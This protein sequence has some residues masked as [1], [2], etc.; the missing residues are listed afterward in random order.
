MIKRITNFFVDIIQKYLP[1]AFVFAI[2]LTII[3]L[4][5]GIIFTGQ[6]LFE[7]ITHWGDGVWGLLAFSMQMALVLVLGHTLAESNFVKRIIKA[8]TKLAN[9]PEQAIFFVSLISAIAC[10]LNWGFGLVIGALYARE[11]VKRI[12]DVDYRLLI[13]SAYSGFIVWHGGF[14]ASIPLTLA[15][16]EADLARETAGAITQAIPTSLTIFS[17]F[18]LILS[19][20]IIFTLPFLN[21]LMLPEEKDRVKVNPALLEEEEEIII[22]KNT[23]AEKIEN[24]KIV[25]YITGGIG[26]VYLYIYFS[27]RGFDLN[28]N[29]VN[30]I[31]LVAGIIAHGTPRSYLDA[32]SKAVQGAGGI[33]LQFPFYAGIMGMMTG[34]PAIGGSSLAGLISNWF[35]NVSNPN[36]FPMFTF[37]AAGLVNFFVPSG[38]GQWAVQAPIMMPAGS[39]LGVNPAITAMA[40]SWG[41][42]WTNMIQPFWALPA[43]GIAGLGARD[44]MGFCTMVFLYTGI[45]ISLAFLLVALI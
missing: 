25:S 18:N 6:S 14:A 29:I 23:P 19:A 38:G 34:E 11:L 30:L 17:P 13:A 26:L 28:L 8:L 21:R 2:F 5:L 37:W 33:I 40:I 1:D 20:L 41:D 15:S 3:T 36:T 22:T 39:S 7:M 42:A 16:T 27:K 12:P 43:L 32:L 45:I 24:S 4:I 35:V 31:F 10:W 44:I 9:T